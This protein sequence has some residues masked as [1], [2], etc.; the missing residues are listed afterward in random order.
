MEEV[1]AIYEMGV[2]ALHQSTHPRLDY[3]GAVLISYNCI[4]MVFR[5]IGR[6]G[7]TQEEKLS[8]VENGTQKR[9]IR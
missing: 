4:N 1:D 3:H 5:E 9:E 8:A 2:L 7:L 6:T